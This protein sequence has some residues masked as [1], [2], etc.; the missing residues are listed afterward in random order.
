LQRQ[1]VLHAT[2]VNRDARRIDSIAPAAVYPGEEE[3]QALVEG[4]LRVLRGE[5]PAPSLDCSL[6]ASV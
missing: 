2:L 4:V 5:E 6:A 3:L 1:R